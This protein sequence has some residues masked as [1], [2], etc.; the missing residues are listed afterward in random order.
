MNRGFRNWSHHRSINIPGHTTPAGAQE[1]ERLS[2]E[3][4]SLVLR[5]RNLDGRFVSHTSAAHAALSLLKN[6]R[7][8]CHGDPR[9]RNSELRKETN[10]LGR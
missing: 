5:V 8:S 7:L 6:D 2:E 9:N 4:A 10:A 1:V 3:K